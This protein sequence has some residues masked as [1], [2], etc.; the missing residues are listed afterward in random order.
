MLMQLCLVLLLRTGLSNI[1]WI[2][3]Q[4]LCS[5]QRKRLNTELG[6]NLLCSS[7]TTVDYILN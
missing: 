1:E 2:A 3:T 5:G 6:N 7:E 4:R